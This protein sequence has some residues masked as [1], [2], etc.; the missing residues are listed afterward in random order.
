M[1]HT[2]SKSEI[3]TNLLLLLQVLKKSKAR[4][5]AFGSAVKIAEPPGIHNKLQWLSVMTTQP[6]IDPSVYTY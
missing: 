2:A 4:S 5:T 1:V 3:I 6:T